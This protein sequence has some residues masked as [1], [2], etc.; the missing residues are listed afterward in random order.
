MGSPASRDDALLARA[1]AEWR[2]H[3]GTGAGLDAVQMVDAAAQ[4]V[5]GLK[6]FADSRT[7]VLAPWPVARAVAEHIAHAAWL[8]EPGIRPEARMAR[9]WMARLAGAYRYRWVA[10]ARKTTKAQ[11]RDAKKCR[12]TIR[13]ELIQRFPDADTEWT[14]PA[15]DPLPPWTIGDETYPTIGRQCRLIEKLGVENL[16]GVYDTLS[17]NAHPNPVT[18]TMQV[19]RINNGGDVTVT[20]RVDPERWNSAVRGAGVLLYAGA[21][22]ACGYFALDAS[23][24]DAWYNRIEPARH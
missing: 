9:R 14:D 18:L 24:L 17:L 8:L 22:A 10:A 6:S 21:R 16:A 12:D 5:L 3:E 13:G 7:P 23:H 1:R 20:Y 19:D 11:E 2:H 4:Y 15:Q